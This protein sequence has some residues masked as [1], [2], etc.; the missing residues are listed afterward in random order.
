M[1][2]D[3]AFGRFHDLVLLLVGFVLTSLVGGYLSYR[4]QTTRAFLEREAEDRRAEK[5]AATKV[6]EEL[7]R[8]MDKRL[9][10]MRRLSD[11]Q[12]TAVEK[13]K[14]RWDSYMLVLFEWNENL[15]RNLA[16]TQRYFGEGARNVLEER[17]QVGFRNLGALLEGNGYPHSV[18]DRTEYRKQV[19]DDLNN[20]I[21]AF[22]VDLISSIQR[23]DVGQFRPNAEG[24][25]STSSMSRESK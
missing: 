14:E 8:M 4:W 6:F 21:Y 24:G 7:S 15:N 17:I 22:D 2:T 13:S 19:A 18:T 20:I 9:Y 23:G 12:N 11:V 5:E 25:S 10:R 16:L 1:A 3:K